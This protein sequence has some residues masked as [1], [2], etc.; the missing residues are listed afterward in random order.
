VAS[1]RCHL[2]GDATALASQTKDPPS[3]HAVRQ[4]NAS[5]KLFLRQCLQSTN[6]SYTVIPVTFSSSLFR[7]SATL[8]LTL[9]LTVIADAQIDSQIIVTVQIRPAEY[10]LLRRVPECSTDLEKKQN[11]AERCTSHATRKKSL[12]FGGNLNHV[13][14]IYTS[15]SSSS[16]SFPF[17]YQVDIRN[18]N[19]SELR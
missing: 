3:Y 9:T 11:S 8:I 14:Y 6:L 19:Y 12:D 7:S 16:S 1:H 13:T 4:N 15:S 2:H 5:P 17:I 18:L 10:S